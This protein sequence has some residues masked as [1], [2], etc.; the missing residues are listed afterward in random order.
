MLNR[1][2]FTWISRCFGEWFAGAIT[3]FTFNHH[4]QLN[5]MTLLRDRDGYLTAS[6]SSKTSALPLDK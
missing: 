1:N 5:P 3:L 6:N 2:I 4:L